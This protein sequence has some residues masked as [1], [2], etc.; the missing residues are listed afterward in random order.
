MQSYSSNNLV[1]KS[2]KT[3]SDSYNYEPKSLI[4]NHVKANAGMLKDVININN[5]N[6][7]SNQGSKSVNLRDYIIVKGKIRMKPKIKCQRKK[8]SP[9]EDKKLKKLVETMNTYKW[10]DIAK[11]MPGRNG[12]QCRDRYKNY[13][14]SSYFNGQWT[15]EEDSILRNKYF[16]L[17][18]QW[19]RLTQFFNNRSCNAIKN[20]WNYYVSKHLNEISSEI[21]KYEKINPYLNNSNKDNNKEQKQDQITF[22]LLDDDSLF[23]Y[24]ID[25]DD[26]E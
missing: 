22:D 7:N 8:F 24:S 17:G 2:L 21:P 14:S 10:D 13:L 5:K 15:V 4:W 20:R 9:E 26:F 3:N 18:P 1:F 25:I 11:Y 12:R 6:I 23:D 19:S 16:E